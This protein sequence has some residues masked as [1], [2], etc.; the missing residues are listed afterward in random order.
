MPWSTTQIADLAGVTVKTVRYY[1]EVGLLDEPARA[2]NGYKLYG[3]AHLVR[4]LHVKRL[5]DLGVP[6]GRARAVID[7]EKEPLQ[8]LRLIDIEIEATIAR[9]ERVRSELTALQ[10][11]GDV[12]NAPAGFDAVGARL[13]DADRA[14]LLVAS[15]VLDDG[16]MDDLRKSLRERPRTEAEDRFDS[17]ASDASETEID[18]TTEMLVARV[19]DMRGEYPWVTAPVLHARRDP[20]SLGDALTGAVTA[21]YNPAQREVLRRLSGS[22]TTDEG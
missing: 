3:V 13:S 2:A 12:T 14:L 4:M 10:V 6:L 8:A 22:V 21:L 16:A 18:R 19:R 17:L 9:L 15:R 7:A 1:H 5:S 20:A 11:H